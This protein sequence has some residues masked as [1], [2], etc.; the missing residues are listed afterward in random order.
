MTNHV[1]LLATPER[2][3]VLATKLQSLGRRYVRYVNATDK[4]SGTLWEGRYK[5]GAVDA[6][7]Y[8]LRVSRYIE[9]NPVR[10]N[11]VL[12][13]RDY[14][15]SSYACNGEGRVSDW[16]VAHPLYA[17]LGETP[18]RAQSLM[19]RCSRPRSIPMKP[20]EFERRSISG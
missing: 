7:D 10:A 16:L 4:R 5:A 17:A 14:G 11:M 20:R 19:R 6:E 1:H 18:L 8:L 13:P 15:W 3:G 2:P 9:L 12:H